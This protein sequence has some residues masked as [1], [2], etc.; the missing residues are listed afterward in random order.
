[1]TEHQKWV[2]DNGDLTHNINYSLDENSVVMDLGG[3]MG[4]WAD[5]IIKKY[6][7]YFYM[8]EPVPEFFVKLESKYQH[9]N[10]MNLLNVGV[11]NIN[12]SGHLF[13]NSDATS[14]NLTNGN[15]VPIDYMNMQGILE[16]F[17]ISEVDLLQI[18]IEGEEY[19]VLENLIESGLIR[20]FKNI[21]IQF[22]T[23]IDGHH[24][25]RDDIRISLL[26]N[27]FGEKFNY[28]FIWEGWERV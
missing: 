6:N 24:R 13:M 28:P 14:A 17:G 19:N 22:H 8:I 12:K 10:K 2:R 3:F 5:Q 27:G 18:N 20:T 4:L 16:E 9:N 7:P 1:M 23:N 25:R 26:E 11:S 15:R 21:Q